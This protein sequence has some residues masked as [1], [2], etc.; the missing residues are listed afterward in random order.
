MTVGLLIGRFQPP[1][2]GHIIAIKNILKKVDML[3]IGIG[4][5]QKCFF[6][7]NPFTAGERIE[8]LKTALEEER[9]DCARYMLIPIQDVDDN[10]LW[11]NHVASLVPRFNIVYTNDKLSNYLFKIA[12]Y[13]ARFFEEYDREKY[14][15]TEVRRRMRE[16]GDW[17]SLV[18]QSVAKIIDEIKGVE[19]VKFIE[20]QSL[21]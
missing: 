7:N 17:R 18:P 20:A 11:V 5:A 19:R 13:D 16:D 3:I 9:I 2:K 12:G 8:M 21:K 6:Q 15:S 4:S 14:S 10:R 1:H